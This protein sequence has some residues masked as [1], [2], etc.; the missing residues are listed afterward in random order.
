MDGI[1]Y[2]EVTVYKSIYWWVH[3]TSTKR[4]GQG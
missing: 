3:N 2:Q 1:E 4:K